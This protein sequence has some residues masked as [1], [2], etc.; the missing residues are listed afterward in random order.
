MFSYQGILKS[1]YEK[2]DDSEKKIILEVWN[3]K[4]KFIKWP[5]RAHLFW[6]GC[7][8]IKYHKY[9][10]KLDFFLRLNH[11]PVDTR[12]NGP[13]VVSYLTAGGER[14]V[15]KSNP[16][17]QWSI[18]HIYDGKHPWINRNDT[19]HAVKDG[20][21]FTQSAGLVALHPVA[22]ALAEEY[23]YFSWLLRLESFK[24]F[25]YD[26]DQVFSS[27]INEYGFKNR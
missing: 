9:P 25:N 22:D 12:S 4:D 2:L 7:K 19:L 6:D 18:H 23:F 15:R 13:A 11:Y 24:K 17:Y 27:K 3:N 8:R 16:K 26:P 1:E 20:K 10:P 5:D 21:H 14:P